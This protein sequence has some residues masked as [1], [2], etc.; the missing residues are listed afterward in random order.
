MVTCPN[1]RLIQLLSWKRLTQTDP[2][3][4]KKAGLHDRY[5]LM[6][7]MGSASHHTGVH[8][9]T[10][11]KT[12]RLILVANSGR[13]NRHR[14]HIPLT[15]SL[16]CPI[17]VDQ[18]SPQVHVLET[19]LDHRIKALLTLI[20]HH[21]PTKASPRRKCNTLLNIRRRS[22]PQRRRQQVRRHSS[23]RNGINH[24]SHSNHNNRSIPRGTPP[25]QV[26]PQVI[27]T[28]E[29]PLAMSQKC[30]ISRFPARKTWKSPRCSGPVNIITSTQ[31]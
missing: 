8:H 1:L 17:S 24:S 19:C 5:P 25:L 11:L 16:L 12:D 3:A 28:L 26:I 15:I 9:E 29:C 7:V 10:S 30:R 6:T 4:I 20:I 21:H 22:L 13:H 31:P 27:L 14:V 18:S 23:R 2:L